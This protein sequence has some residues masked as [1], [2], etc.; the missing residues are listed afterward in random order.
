LW[1]PARWWHHR[2]VKRWIVIAMTA[3]AGAARADCP[4]T[5][6]DALCRPWTAILLPTA[7][8]TYYAPHGASGPWLGGGLE[9][10]TVWSDNTPAFGPS[11]GKLR[12]DVGALASIA[13]TPVGTTMGYGTMVMYRG[14]AQ[15]SFERNAS[16]PWLI[17]YFDADIGGLWTSATG[18]RA[19]VDGGLGVY[20]WHKRGFIVDLEVDGLLP[21]SHPGDFGGVHTQLAVSFALW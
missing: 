1:A 7:Y 21:F 2:R 6:D 14:G 5:P 17:P 3:C 15:V 11:Q 16:R 20:L 12:F 4:S 19:F 8:A 18:S 13:L 10:S 9:V